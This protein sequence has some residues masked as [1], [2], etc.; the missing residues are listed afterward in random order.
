MY[1]LSESMTLYGQQGRLGGIFTV[2]FNGRFI[3]IVG[4]A[5]KNRNGFRNHTNFQPFWNRN[6]VTQKCWNR[7][8]NQNSLESESTEKWNRIQNYLFDWAEL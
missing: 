7:N 5:A 4:A 6:Q 1:R 3:T 2:Q 8:R